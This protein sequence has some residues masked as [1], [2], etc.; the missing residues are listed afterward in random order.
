MALSSWWYDSMKG[1]ENRG[2]LSNLVCVLSQKEGLL[3]FLPVI[4]CE[5]PLYFAYTLQA[6][7]S[8]T[9]FDFLSQRHYL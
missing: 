9:V 8:Q 3:S 7:P 4:F 5:I 6:L 2:S 1:Q